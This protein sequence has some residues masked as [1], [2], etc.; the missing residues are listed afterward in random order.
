MFR[1]TS[2]GDFGKT[3]KFIARMQRGDQYTDLNRY[4]Q[5]GVEA[6]S[7]ATPVDTG[8]ASQSWAY[9][10]VKDS[11]G[12]RIEWYNTDVE[13]GAKVILLVRYGHATRSG[14]YIQ[15]RNFISPAAQPVFDQIVNDV[16]KK[17]KTL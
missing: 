14:T 3:R 17:V 4:G 7:R 2:K 16:W 8:L 5:M 9:R 13:N 6:L 1:L 12:P 15:G 11:R 10:I